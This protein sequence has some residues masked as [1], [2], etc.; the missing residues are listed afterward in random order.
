MSPSKI[1]K[2]NE[3]KEV[4]E[5]LKENKP[6]TAKNLSNKSLFNQ[7]FTDWS[8]EAKIKILK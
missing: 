1:L 3:S 5:K 4:F 2:I 8:N 6:I 7:R